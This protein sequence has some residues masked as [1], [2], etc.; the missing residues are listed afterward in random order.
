MAG[1]SAAELPRGSSANPTEVEGQADASG[2][3]AAPAGGSSTCRE[4]QPGVSSTTQEVSFE[5]ATAPVVSCRSGGHDDDNDP[6][7]GAGSGCVLVDLRD[8]DSSGEEV[9]G[10][11][12]VAA[13]G[14]VPPPWSMQRPVVTEPRP[15]P[16]LSA[17]EQARRPH[18]GP[19]PQPQAHSARG[20]APQRPLARL[21][22]ASTVHS[23]AV[24]PQELPRP[25]P[26]AHHA[27][28][29]PDTLS[30]WASWTRTAS[31][32]STSAPLAAPTG[33]ASAGTTQQIPGSAPC[34]A[35]SSG[36]TDFGLL[37]T[38]RSHVSSILEVERRELSE[39]E[40]EDE[41]EED[42][43]NE[44]EGGVAKCRDI[45]GRDGNV[46]SSS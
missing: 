16:P 17:R 24:Q 36:P 14:P 30:P 46:S 31:S 40:S 13:T 3:S 10:L 15:P 7:L 11:S 27:H 28:Q 9:S 43:D 29:S 33:T 39:E 19:P 12:A 6:V 5:T 45:G 32:A 34:S 4:P 20:A 21:P 26:K 41:G 22:W 44:G 23:P 18:W 8:G 35:R 2:G 42:E 1:D 37:D 25:Q 38:P